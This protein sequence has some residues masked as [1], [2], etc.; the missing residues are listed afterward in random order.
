MAGV[1]V[2]VSAVQGGGASHLERVAVAAGE[3]EGVVGDG[4][5]ADLD[6]VAGVGGDTVHV[7]GGRSR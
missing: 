5:V 1:Q 7:D 3:G 6:L 2:G 4:E